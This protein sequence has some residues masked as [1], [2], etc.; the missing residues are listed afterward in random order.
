MDLAFPVPDTGD[1]TASLA[2]RALALRRRDPAAAR[3]LA[4]RAVAAAALSGDKR[5]AHRAAAALG[6]VLAATPAE[7]ARGRELLSAALAGCGAPGDERMRAEVLNELA[8]SHL[9]TFEHDSA[10]AL[11]REGAAAGRAAGAADEEARGLRLAGAALAGKGEFVDALTTLLQAVA[12]HES[13]VSGAAEGMDEEARWERGELFGRIAIVYSN[14]DQFEQALA[15]YRVALE[16]FG[17]AHPRDAARTLYRMGI[18]AQEL[19]D[20]AAT[21]EFYRGSFALYEREGDRAGAAIGLL[22]MAKVMADRRE[23]GE[24]ERT[25]TRALAVFRADPAYEAFLADALW[26]LSDLHLQTG[27]AASALE[28]L[29]EA[30]P[31]YARTARPAAHEAHLQ[32]RL[33]RACAALGRFE[34]ALLHHERFHELRVKHLEEQASARM[35][36][37]MVRFDTERA[38]RDREIHRLRTIELEREVAERKEAE[39]AL[40]RA[41]GELEEIN[42]ELHALTIRDP[43]TGAFNR[44]YLGQRLADALALAVRGVQPLGVMICDIDDFKRINDTFSHAVGDEVLR[45]VAGVLMRSVRQS[46][47]V[48]RFGGEEF[49]VLFPAATLRQ[50]AAASEKVCRLVREVD[51][52]A[53]HPGLAVTLSAGVAAAGRA[54]TADALLAEADRRLYAAKRAGKDRVVA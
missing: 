53:V 43:L 26:L 36:A 50:A 5:T 48:A 16:A 12:V 4:E 54:S 23:W 28:L 42:R 29:H 45:A 38:V 7:A 1:S 18:A 13:I 37:M 17:E 22:G 2:Q 3:L 41:R 30:L 9:A 11:A 44:R 24:A 51:W 14:M 46:D 20:R 21:E 19:G 39:A 33:S 27:R 15:Y 31:L 49:V 40:A 10:I 25:V 34:E 8:A 6:A 47:V 52:N 32:H 35:A